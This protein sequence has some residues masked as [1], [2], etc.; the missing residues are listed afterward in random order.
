MHRK[1]TKKELEEMNQAKAS[2]KGAAKGKTGKPAIVAAAAV[3][4]MPEV[5]PLGDDCH[6]ASCWRI[7]FH[8]NSAYV[9]NENPMHPYIEYYT[10]QAPG[11]AACDN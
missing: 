9:A 5:C 8:D 10:P 1:G 6:D 11:N 7:R 2:G 4:E 3:E